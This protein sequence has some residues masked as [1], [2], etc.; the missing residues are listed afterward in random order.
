MRLYLDDDRYYCFGCAAKGDVIQWVRDA[1]G[2]GVTDA[3]SHL[4]SRRPITNTWAGR[5]LHAH[6]RP[7]ASGS[8]WQPGRAEPPNLSRTSPERVTEALQA[9]WAHY[10]SLP[11][12]HRGSDYLASRGIDVSILEDRN[13]RYEVGHTPPEP[14]G[15]VTALRSA[16]YHDDELIDAGLAQRYHCQGKLTDFYRERV[17]VPIHGGHG[18]VEGLIGRNVGDNRHPKYKNPP[19]T[20]LYDKSVNLYQPLPA[21]S[22]PA[23]RVV[24]VEGTLDALAIA[25]AAV[26][27]EQGSLF[28]PVT[29]SGRELSEVQIRHILELHAGPPVLGFDADAAGLDSAARYAV[30]FTHLGAAPLVAVL[31]PDHDPASWLAS[32]GPAGL[33][34]WQEGNEAGP[35]PCP[36]L[37]PAAAFLAWGSCRGRSSSVA[38]PRVHCAPARDLDGPEDLV[39]QDVVL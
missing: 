21:P 26:K 2:L 8:N 37:V 12:H 39:H 13:G 16:G 33:A 14:A 15:L 17:L 24:I 11:L 22:H 25:V 38:K 32:T 35:G 23:G 3:I 34:V 10:S 4:D 28:C 5:P 20:H 6:R 1:E 19:C 29:Q 27:S 31:P 30:S 18:G 7:G 36:Q 9:A